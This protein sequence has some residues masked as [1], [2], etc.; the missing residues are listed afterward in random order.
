MENYVTFRNEGRT[1]EVLVPTSSSEGN[2]VIINAYRRK[3]KIGKAMIPL[4]H[5]PSYS[6]KFNTA[7]LGRRD[8]SEIEKVLSRLDEALSRS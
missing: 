7:L 3:I 2:S 4:K 1:Y 6:S 5:K 8:E